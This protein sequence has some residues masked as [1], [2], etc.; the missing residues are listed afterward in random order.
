MTELEGKKHW[1]IFDAKKKKSEEERKR[2][3]KKDNCIALAGFLTRT[4]YSC[5]C[6][7]ICVCT[8]SHSICN[9][10]IYNPILF[11][12]IYNNNHKNKR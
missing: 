4:P 6:I 3:S 8:Q 11:I 9:L 10:S 7:C 5:I 1:K 12:F 2:E